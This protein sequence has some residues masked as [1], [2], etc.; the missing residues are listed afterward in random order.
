MPVY[1]VQVG[2]TS[3]AWAKLLQK[4]QDRAKAVGAAIEKLGGRVVG[5]W[6][7]F[8]DDDV[9]MVIEMPDNTAA[10]AFA[11]AV[12]AGGACRSFKTTPLMPIAEAVGAMQKASTCGYKP[13]S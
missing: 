10:A 9:I 12:G 5:S 7:A 8:G 11:M 1:L 2:Y 6:M 4:P 3:E 13:P